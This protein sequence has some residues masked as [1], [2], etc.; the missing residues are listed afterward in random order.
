MR[1]PKEGI[2]ATVTGAFPGTELFRKHFS[3]Q[4]HTSQ[5]PFGRSLHV[6]IAPTRFFVGD[7]DQ[8]EI[9]VFSSDGTLLHVVR[10]EGTERPVTRKAIEEYMEDRIP[11][12]TDLPR[13]Y[14]EDQLQALITHGTLP[15]FDKL[16]SDEDGY[17]WVR[18]F[19]HRLP[20]DRDERW[21]V[22]DPNGRYLGALEMPASFSLMTITPKYIAGVSRNAGGAE[23]VR[24]Y[25]LKKPGRK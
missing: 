23:I 12:R 18:D 10:L 5:P 6:A 16:L 14:L 20:A 7:N 24:V 17:L 9:S 8:Y 2:P 19:D 4:S 3:N 1:A 15:A 11:K 21:N 25:E 22:F 13:K